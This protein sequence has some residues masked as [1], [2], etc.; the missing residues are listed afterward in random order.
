[1]RERQAGPLSSLRS[2]SD[3]GLTL[4]EPLAHS[5]TGFWPPS[6]ESVTPVM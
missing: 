1:M 2:A 4:S 3:G 5:T 6:I